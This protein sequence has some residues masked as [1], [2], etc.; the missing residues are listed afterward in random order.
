MLPVYQVRES[1]IRAAE[2]L[3]EPDA[4]V[5]QRHLRRQARLKAIQV[6]RTLTA[7]AKSMVEL[8]VDGLHDLTDP[9]EP[10][11]HALRPGLVAIALRRAQHLRSVTMPPARVRGLPL[12]ALI[13]DI[14]PEGR[15]SDTQASRVGSLAQGEEGLGQRLVFGTGGAN[16]IAGN[17]PSGG[18]RHEQMEAFVPAQPI[19]PAD[20][21]EPR[22]PASPSPFGIPCWHRRAVQGFIGCVATVQTADQVP[23]EGHDGSI[24]LAQQAVELGAM[25]QPGKSGAQL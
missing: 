2:W 12:E 17:D 25:G 19:A 16:T 23:E 24:V 8:V 11:A 22:Q 14:G 5:V 6:V 10:A 15:L 7:K 1:K 9:G 13:T 20:I 3:I 21:G 4:E 18:D